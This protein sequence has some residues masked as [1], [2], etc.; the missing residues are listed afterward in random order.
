MPLLN[1][2][3][4]SNKELSHMLNNETASIRASASKILQNSNRIKEEPMAFVS[5]LDSEWEDTQEFIFEMFNSIGETLNSDTLIAIC[6]ST[7]EKVQRFG[8]KLLMANFKNE[9][10][11]QYIM[12]LSEH[13]S[14]NLQLFVS[15]FLE[16]ENLQASRIKYLNSYH[17]LSTA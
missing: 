11:L 6:D 5:A 3:D 10:G 8:R 9:D 14:Q 16:S 15:T 7:Q 4:F 2:E 1:S 17:L 12:Q 13:P